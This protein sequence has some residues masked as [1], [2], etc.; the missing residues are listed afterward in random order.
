[1]L[2]I[3]FNANTDAID[4]KIAA[5][6]K[7]AFMGF[8]C[9]QASTQANAPAGIWSFGAQGVWILGRDDKQIARANDI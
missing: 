7:R 6:M 5:V 8:G 1:M 3:P 9:G 2:I 4:E